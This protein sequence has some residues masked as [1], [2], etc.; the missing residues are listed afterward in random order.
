MTLINL[1]SHERLEVF[2]DDKLTLV[3]YSHHNPQASVI[4]LDS[5]VTIR[6]TPCQPEEDQ[7]GNDSTQ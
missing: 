1:C 6:Q 7:H 3:V 4:R 5:T 2:P